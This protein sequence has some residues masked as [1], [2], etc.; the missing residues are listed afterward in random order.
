MDQTF[1]RFEIFKAIS[2]GKNLTKVRSV[3]AAILKE[4]HSTYTIRLNTFI[5]EAF[6]LLPGDSRFTSA[7][8][9][10]MSRQ[11]ATKPGKKYIW[12]PVGEGRIVSDGG[13]PCLHL[14][15]DMIGQGDIYM[16]MSPANNK[17]AE[18]FMAEALRDVLKPKE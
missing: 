9:T 12:R 2:D 3:G 14:T 7:E 13:K 4:G 8:Y 15:W 18:D 16:E 17:T 5:S 1:Y 6:Y 11:N 10:I